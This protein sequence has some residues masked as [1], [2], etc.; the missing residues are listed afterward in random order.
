M[1]RL[2]VFLL[3]PLLSGTEGR[4]PLSRHPSVPRDVFCASPLKGSSP[5]RWGR[6][7]SVLSQGCL[8]SLQSSGQ[9][10]ITKNSFAR[11]LKQWFIQ[12]KL[13]VVVTWW[14]CADSNGFW[15]LTYAITESGFCYLMQFHISRQCSKCFFSMLHL[16][17]HT[18]EEVF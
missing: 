6:H 3:L 14:H 17:H 16:Q 18:W 8:S 4:A 11:L 13:C 2:H 12:R 7:P 10:Q 15:T 9:S 1:D 5:H